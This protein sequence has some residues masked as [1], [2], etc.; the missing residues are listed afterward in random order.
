MQ[1]AFTSAQEPYFSDK[2]TV[3]QTSRKTL[4]QPKKSYFRPLSPKNI[5]QTSQNPNSDLNSRQFQ[6]LKTLIQPQISD[7]KNPNSDLNSKLFQT[8]NEP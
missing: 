1:K 8:P 6:T 2:K 4:I 5:L 3:I 7:P